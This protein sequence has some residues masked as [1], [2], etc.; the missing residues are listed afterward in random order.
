[1]A[2]IDIL[3]RKSDILNWINEHK[4]KAYICK[5][6]NCKPSTLNSWLQKMKL[7]Y[8]GNRGSKGR[9]STTKLSA[10]ELSTRLHVSSHLLKL[11][12]IDDGLR[13]HKCESCGRRKWNG[14]KIPIEL[15]HVDGNRFN[16][17]FG[18][19][20]ILCPN[21]HALTDTNSGKNINRSLRM[22]L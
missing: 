20:Q 14:C 8:D 15:H 3:K 19:L 5:Q 6:L 17:D 21:C 12:L 4:S 10:I 13:E 18:N 1:M 9:T 16:N 7:V 2:R 22:P 11:R